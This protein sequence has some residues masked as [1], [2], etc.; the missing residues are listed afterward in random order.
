L[1]YRNNASF[2]KPGDFALANTTVFLYSTGCDDAPLSVRPPI[3]LAL[4]PERTL[5][6]TKK[7]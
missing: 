4:L 7:P 2:I 6:T 1:I 3:D 5:W